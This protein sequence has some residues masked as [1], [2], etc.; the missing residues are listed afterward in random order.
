MSLTGKHKVKTT[1]LKAGGNLLLPSRA[2]LI[3]CAVMDL[4][5]GL[6]PRART[7]KKYKHPSPER[8]DV[9]SIWTLMVQRFLLVLVGCLCKRVDRH[10]QP[11]ESD[12]LS[13]TAQRL[14]MRNAFK[15]L[16]GH[17]SQNVEA[18]GKVR[19]LISWSLIPL[20]GRQFQC[21][22]FAI[23]VEELEC[24]DPSGTAHDPAHEIYKAT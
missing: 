12:S 13:T 10:A 18:F 5:A 23:I 4:K 6:H 9:F 8:R 11:R 17:F 21:A 1:H 19:T 22:V 16:L 2:G 20:K 7:G 15:A 14:R 24:S 3:P